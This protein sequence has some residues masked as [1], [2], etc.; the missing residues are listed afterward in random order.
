MKVASVVGARPNFIKAALVSREL[1]KR[2]I[3]EFLIH[4]GQHYDIEMDQLLFQDIALR[5]PDVNLGVG[6][7]THAAQTSKAMI[8]IEMLLMNRSVDAV[9]VYGDT[10][11]SL[12]GTLAA[13]KLHLPVIHVEAGGRIGDR[14][15][16]E[17]VNRIVCDHLATVNCCATK[18]DM[19]N[20]SREGV[21]NSVWTG[22]VMLDL[23]RAMRN[24]AAKPSLKIPQRF[25][26][27]TIHREENTTVDRSRKILSILGSLEVP[28][29]F[30]RHPRMRDVMKRHKTQVSSQVVMIPPVS[31]R[32]ML[33]LEQHALRIITDSGGVQKEAYWIG[34]P[35]VTILSKTP[36]S[37][38]LVGKWNQL[39]WDTLEEIPRRLTAQPRGKP[40]T[41]QF[42][43]GHAAKKIV[44][45][46]Q[47]VIV[48]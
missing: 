42:G 24:K 9:I 25:F 23:Y 15:S 43:D 44:D 47:R 31:Y 28:V 11:S 27:A 34:T 3:S 10:N 13:A 35:C 18:L 37:Q 7:G 20:L 32:Q 29:I 36:W 6:S 1:R 26:L 48:P 5:T 46:I 4:T 40:N 16:P 19:R 8:G 17:E 45:I 38:T 2:K 41:S 33:W 30:P 39:V 14:S 12:A 22:D 21:R